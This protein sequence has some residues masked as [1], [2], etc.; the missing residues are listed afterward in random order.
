MMTGEMLFLSAVLVVAF[1]VA[2]SFTVDSSDS[3]VMFLNYYGYLV[4]QPSVDGSVNTE[5]DM[6]KAIC[7]FQHMANLEV[8]CEL[9]NA[10]MEK[11]NEP[12]CGMPDVV[13]HNFDAKRKRRFA[14]G[15]RWPTTDLTFRIDNRTPDIPNPDD[16]DDTLIA[17]LQVWADVTPLTFTRVFGDTPADIIITF[18]QTDHRDGN[19]FD[20][21]RGVLAHAFFPQ[22]GNAHFDEAERWTINTNDGI[23][24]FQVAAHEFGHSLGLGHSDIEEALMAPFYRGY[25]PDFELH[26]DDIAG[27]QAHY[28]VN[29]GA[30]DA[31]VETNPATPQGGQCT[32][33]VDS[34]TTSQDRSTYIFEGSNVWKIEFNANQIAAGFPKTISSTFSG[35]PDYIDAALYNQADGTNHYFKGSQYWQFQNEV[36]DPGFPQDISTG[37]PGLPDDLDAAFAWSG[38]GR[39]YFIKGDQYYRFSDDGVDAGYPRA[40]SVWNIPGNQVSAAV[41]GTNSRTYF[42]TPDGVYYRFNDQQFNVA[43]GYPRDTAE[44]WQGCPSAIRATPDDGDNGVKGH[45]P[46]LVALVISSLGAFVLQNY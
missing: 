17:A 21:P 39:F 29:S 42:F 10:T 9:D 5:E 18:D 14:L 41:Q 2:N 30:P 13:G 8:T 40:L 45:L 25:V 33:R 24:L 1:T 23:N 15:S 7:N 3:A 27:I 16:V 32:G 43:A 20:G 6:T 19:P 22:S 34:V 36:M 35:L 44:N 46:S 38:N 31:T 26:S 12:R 28:G 11:M 37:Y 4:R